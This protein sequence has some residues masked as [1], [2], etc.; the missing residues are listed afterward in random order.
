[1]S[2]LNAAVLSENEDSLQGI[3]TKANRLPQTDS[4]AKAK[5]LILSTAR[6]KLGKIQY[7]KISTETS[8]VISD[9]QHAVRIANQASLLR[10]A[11]NAMSSAA[12][13]SSD[14]AV[15]AFQSSRS[16]VK[17][18]LNVQLDH[19]RNEIAR[20]TLESD[21]AA[22][23]A[24]TLFNEA[25]ELLIEADNLDDVE[26]LK[27]LKQGMRVM[28]KSNLSHLAA[29]SSEVESDI[30][31]TPEVDD[32]SVQLEAIA[33]QLNAI[34]HSM[35]LLGTYRQASREGAGQL[36]SLADSRDHECAS[37]L[38]DA[39]SKASD[40]IARWTSATDLLTKS[41][42]SRGGRSTGS[43][44]SKA[45][46]TSWKLQTS[47]S[48]G[49]M[50]ESQVAF[51]S[52]ECRA[53]SEIIQTGIVNGTSKW[54]ALYS[55][56]SSQLDAL[57]AAAISSYENAKNAAQELGRDGEGSSFQLDVRIAKLSGTE[58]P[59]NPQVS[60]PSNPMENSTPSKPTGSNTGFSTPQDL[61]AF[62]NDSIQSQ[63]SIELSRIYET[64]TNEQKN[65]LGKLQA[66]SDNMIGLKNT[67]DSTFGEG[68]SSK[69]TLL[70]Q[71]ILPESIDPSSIVMESDIKATLPM[72]AISVSLLK[73]D[74]G[75]L[76]DFKSQADA[77][78]LDAQK[79]AQMEKLISAFKK[80][81][82]QI[83]NGEI[84]DKGQIEFAIM[85]SMM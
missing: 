85:T 66:L 71:S 45:A 82:T 64:K 7:Q 1:M 28:R 51:L 47:W 56:C 67:I 9:F 53:L 69:I 11:A 27:S 2:D 79:F 3:I 10:S 17:K 61:V 68:T 48:L 20:L 25:N 59:V 34:R 8:Q 15:A 6:A 62:M 22:A 63:S 21:E 83:I 16:L 65:M 42:S 38:T 39:S 80:V 14:D 52:A 35:E 57:T 31:A 75:W 49:Q 33:S 81:Q 13:Q 44:Q 5:K 84:A 4:V 50:Q 32:A 40:I 73:T 29:V 24:D 74:R 18:S 54:E 55:S 37:I 60:K 76:I 58:A 23:M 46:L 77:E 70:S 12:E 19:A 30:I 78:G 41:L 72:D 43:K 26:G 36:R